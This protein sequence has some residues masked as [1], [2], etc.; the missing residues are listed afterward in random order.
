MKRSHL[1]L[2]IMGSMWLF[3]KSK[4][5]SLPTPLS[6][7]FMFIMEPEVNFVFFISQQWC[8]W[9]LTV[10]WVG[11]NRSSS[12]DHILCVLW[13]VLLW[14]WFPRNWLIL[15]NNNLG[16]SFLHSYRCWKEYRTSTGRICVSA[17]SSAI[18]KGI[19][20][21]I[22]WWNPWMCDF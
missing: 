22:P 16:D 14:F 11:K 17:L 8:Q 9:A 3:W 12:T 2:L 15:N 13:L 18:S 19:P 10:A 4:E 21:W 7:S 5:T 20:W 6:N 1:F